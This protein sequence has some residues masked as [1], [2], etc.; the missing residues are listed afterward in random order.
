MV[1]SKLAAGINFIVYIMSPK[2]VRA[3]VVILTYV[4]KKIK[5]KGR[6]KIASQKRGE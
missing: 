1:A 6:S 5:K 3:E 4:I 2:V